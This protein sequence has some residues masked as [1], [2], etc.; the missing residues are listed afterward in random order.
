MISVGG[1]HLKR[2]A[3]L[4]ISIAI[5]LILILGSVNIQGALSQS[6]GNGWTEPVN[7]SKTGSSKNPTFAV[8][9][10]GKIHVVWEDL[11]A[12]F[13]YSVFNGLEWNTPVNLK[14]PFEDAEPRF[15]PDSSQRFHVFWL[16]NRNRLV[17]N[18]TSSE[19]FIVGWNRNIVL[20][21]NVANF[22]LEIDD[23]GI[24]H[25][26]YVQ[27]SST[28]ESVAG[29]Y[30]LQS[31]N[32]GRSWSA[33]TSLYQ[34]PYLRGV[35]E[36]NSTID[37]E[38][39]SFGDQ[40]RILITWDQQAR[41]QTFFI[42]SADEGKT[43]EEAAQLDGP[44]SGSSFLSPFKSKI[45]ASGE[46]VLA[47][48]NFGAPSGSCSQY[49][50]W[51]V[52][53]GV[54]WTSKQSFNENLIACPD[55]HQ[56]FAT[57]EGLF[58][59]VNVIQNQVYLMAWN[60]SQW[61]PALSQPK[62]TSFQDS[63]TLIPVVL[64]CRHFALANK[65]TLM[66]VGCDTGPGGD[67]WFTQRSVSS[68]DEWFP[69]ASAWSKPY[70]IVKTPNE[71][72]APLI[73]ADSQEKFHLLWNQVVKTGDSPSASVV[74]LH[75]KGNVWSPPSD[76]TRLTGNSVRQLGGSL[77]SQNRLLL[78][79]T[80]TEPKGIAFSWANAGTVNSLLDWLPS[81]TPPL[82]LPDAYFPVVAADPAGRILAAYTIPLNE[83][84]GVYLNQSSDGGKSWTQPLQVF[85]GVSA[86]WQMVDQPALAVGADSS[87]HLTWLK[88]SLPQDDISMGFFYSRSADGGETWTDATAISEGPVEWGTVIAA[89]PSAVHRLWAESESGRWLFKHQASQDNGL[90]W[91]ST[92]V[93][94]ASDH[95]AVLPAVAVDR[96]G[97]IHLFLVNSAGDRSVIQ[98]WI[99]KKNGWQLEDAVQP[100]MPP[101]SSLSW[102]SASISPL[103]KLGLAYAFSAPGLEPASNIFQL[104]F[105]SR[106]YELPQSELSTSASP[107][108]VQ[109]IA[110]ATLT[111]ESRATPTNNLS[112]LP[113]STITP[114]SSVQANNPWKGIILSVGITSAVILVA[115]GLWRFFYQRNG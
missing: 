82:P 2:A 83:K 70:T 74:Y 110:T 111:P 72:K 29:I 19:G 17:Y 41:R 45:V 95:R 50:I 12:G 14:P 106:I 37:I 60:G 100:S 31:T 109:L 34:S 13:M 11:F 108:P 71:I 98:H 77:D 59:L 24:L 101:E 26:A 88:K 39:S 52:N 43:W 105:V 32:G 85:D 27:S 48:W 103:G 94:S 114:A 53:G 84:R 62:L 15:F 91:N 8:D 42:Q 54:S 68:A 75:S 20:A 96:K 66:A 56:L 79:W 51:S 80:T 33:A 64:G 115:F 92:V 112:L 36:G 47:V 7:L 90:S 9:Q 58:I 21:L 1:G 18:R 61:S 93:I 46:K 10:S 55:D 3:M 76:L 25:L 107:S 97:A 65:S 5:G 104:D 113:Y 40:T 44:A 86:A 67:I 49:Y 35:T 81:T 4:L 23:K 38:S 89:N 73:F 99:W 69:P 57:A 78:A 6:A 87:Y 16:D 22:D 30:Y 28:S 102:I 63:A